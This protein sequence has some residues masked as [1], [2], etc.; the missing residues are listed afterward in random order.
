MISRIQPAYGIHSQVLSVTIEGAGFV[1]GVT[2]ISFG[3]GIEVRSV[4][5]NATSLATVISIAE[6]ASLG[7][8]TVTATNPA[9]GG[10]S[11]VLRNAFSV[12]N[13][14]PTL[15][16]AS[17]D[18]GTL[19]QSVVILLT[20]SDFVPGGISLSLGEGI[21]VDSIVVLDRTH[22]QA[23]LSISAGTRCGPRD[24]VVTNPDPG[25]G[26][27]TLVDG[28]CVANPAPR[29]LS[30]APSICF[31]GRSA[32]LT[33][34]G[35]CFIPGTSTVSLSGGIRVDSVHVVN[36]AQILITIAVARD[37]LEGSTTITVKN[38]WPGGGSS[39]VAKRLEVY[40]PPPAVTGIL[41]D[42]GALGQSVE[43]LLTGADFFDFVTTVA[44]GNGV[45]VNSM[46]CDSN[47]TNARV[48]ITI[49]E[50]ASVGSR[51][52]VL[53][54]RTPGGGEAI[55]E[56]A[57][58]IEYPVPTLASVSPVASPRGETLDVTL[59]GGNFVHGE[60]TIAFGVGV[61]VNSIEFVNRSS[62]LA[63]VT[64]SSD[65][66]VGARCVGVTNPQPG[67][68]SAELP[69]VFNVE[70]RAPKI[71]R[72]APDA[73]VKGEQMN[74]TVEGAEF[75]GGATSAEFGAGIAVDSVIVKSQTDMDA[76]I[77]IARDALSGSR[78]VRVVNALPGGGFGTLRG[79]FTVRNPPP[80]I[81]SVSPGQAERGRTLSVRITGRRFMIGAASVSFGADVSVSEIVVRN[82]SELQALVEIDP[83]AV[84]GPRTVTVTNE[85]P[86]GGAAD[87]KD[88]FLITP[89]T[90]TLTE[91]QNPEVPD[92][93]VVCKA[94]PNPF[95]LSTRIRFGLPERTRTKIEVFNVLGNRI[96]VLID[97]EQVPGYHELSWQAS[98]LPSGVYFLR[99]TAQSAESD[100]KFVGLWRVALVK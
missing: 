54:N 30:V 7:P 92:Y 65:A 95:N 12:V 82:D 28:F 94:F 52:L 33:V 38:P 90:P 63:N 37:F 83:T 89:A 26:T 32:V 36:S 67:G 79:A 39:S 2:T 75:A 91:T 86:D 57:F 44:L 84:P 99:L 15:T 72:I 14:V 60:T 88:G 18:E 6:G 74:V 58:T 87:L 19:G 29:I 22:L 69:H 97:D 13:P 23:R 48:T 59:N 98:G 21:A 70:R 46:T 68:G 73:G 55:L 50:S 62:L 51:N 80:E 49:A 47:G 78:D 3:D 85:G 16:L 34:M 93:Y 71:T 42:R 40:N 35:E 56:K 1:S 45:T 17:P 64:V 27:A 53:T 43:L 66:V 100:K 10:G 76:Y 61:C 77:R 31:R 41:P 5:G 8:R 24:I 9:P 96:T 81:V 11:S 4:A 25:G 20:G